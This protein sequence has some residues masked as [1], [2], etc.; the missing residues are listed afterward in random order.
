MA[1]LLRHCLSLALCLLLAAC[2]AN[3]Q[4]RDAHEHCGAALRGS[5]WAPTWSCQG[6]MVCANEARLSAPERT[7]VASIGRRLGCAP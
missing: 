3:W 2:S 6:V 7:R 1:S 5:P 4:D